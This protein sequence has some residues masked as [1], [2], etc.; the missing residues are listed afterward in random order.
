MNAR[1]HVA[2]NTNGRSSAIDGRTTRHPGYARSQR[3]RTRIEEAFGWIKFIAG[4]ER[5]KFRG[6]E[7]VALAFTFAAAAYNL[8]RL[9]KLLWHERPRRMQADRPLADRRGRYLGSQTSRSLWAS[10]PHDH[11]H[12]RGEIAFGAL[13]ASLEFVGFIWERSDEMDEVRGEGSA[14]LDLDGS[15][16]IE[17]AYHDGDEAVLKAKR[18][19]SST[20]CY[21]RF[22]LNL[23]DVEDLRASSSAVIPT[24]VSL[25]QLC[26]GFCG[27]SR[28]RRTAWGLH[29]GC[30][31][32]E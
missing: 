9:P 24:L 28:S 1:P 30:P 29:C 14:E 12:G 19:T 18:D 15:I 32:N 16:E 5:T 3:I 22:T 8:A 26:R 20:A 27:L 4:Q 2:Q 6:R 21:V 11:N 31:G 10:N 25:G 23:R 7:R 13:Q 17:F